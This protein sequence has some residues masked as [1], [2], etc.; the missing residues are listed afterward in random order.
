MSMY[1]ITGQLIN[2]IDDYIVD[3]ETGDQVKTPRIQILGDMPVKDTGQVRNELVTLKVDDLSD[4]EKLKGQH[5]AVPFG[6]FSPQK[7]TVIQFVPKGA[8]PKA[9]R[10][11]SPT[12]A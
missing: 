7:G 6:M 9:V 4:Y 2:T 1:T 5:V 11:N 12:G 10:T 8:K 3:R